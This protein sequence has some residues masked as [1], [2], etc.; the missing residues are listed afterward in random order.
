MVEDRG[1][2]FC[3]CYPTGFEVRRV[4][5][6]VGDLRGVEEGGRTDEK[7]Q[8]PPLLP[9]PLLSYVTT[10]H[11]ASPKAAARDLTT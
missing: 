6:S 5:V 9:A 7:E 1:V 8:D 4:I 2:I 11:P 3:F 10:P